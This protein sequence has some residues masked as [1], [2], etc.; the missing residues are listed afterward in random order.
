[1]SCATGGNGSQAAEQTDP[2]AG[3]SHGAS[4]LILLSGPRNSEHH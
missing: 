3:A 1:M 4:L 2:E